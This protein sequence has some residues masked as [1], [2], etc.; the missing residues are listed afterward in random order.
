MDPI[1]LAITA[2]LGNLG[3]NVI[4]DAYNAL[5]AAL[6]HKFGV[7]SDLVEAVDKLER[8]PDSQA[9]QAVLQEE[10]ETAKANQ[11][12]EL[13]KVAEALLEKLKDL[14]GGQ[15]KITQDVDIKGNR[16]IVTGQGDVTINE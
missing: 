4:Q 5:K 8:K 2:A 10:V 9:R 13:V 6:Q 11:D 14:S 15:V 16:N 12:P 7:D 3:Q 1:T